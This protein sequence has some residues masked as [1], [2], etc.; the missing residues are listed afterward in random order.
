MN[1]EKIQ[2]KIWANREGKKLASG[3]EI[4]SQA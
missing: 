4:V 2:I 1:S 3:K